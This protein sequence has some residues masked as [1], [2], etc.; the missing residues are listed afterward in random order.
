MELGGVGLIYMGRRQG[1]VGKRERE[2]EVEIQL[3][4]HSLQLRRQCY[5]A[6]IILPVGHQIFTKQ[7][8]SG[9][10]HYVENALHT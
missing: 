10:V 1:R 8:K 6:E 9:A 4:S 3:L 5:S 2:R 7:R